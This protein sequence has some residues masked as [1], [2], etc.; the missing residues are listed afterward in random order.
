MASMAIFS[1]IFSCTPPAS[2]DEDSQSGLNENIS[3][4]ISVSSITTQTAKVTVTHD[5]EHTDTWYGFATTESDLDA[6]IEAK[7]DELLEP[8][9][10]TALKKTTSTTINLTGLEPGTAYEYVAFG[11]TEDGTV[12]GE[13]ASVSFNTEAAPEELAFKVNPAW[14]VKYLD[15]GTVNGQVYDNIISVESSDK[16]SYFITVINYSDW[17]VSSAAEIFASEL[18][19]IRSAAESNGY[20]FSDY[21]LTGSASQPWILPP[22]TE[23]IAI[24]V[25]VTAEGQLTGLYSLSDRIIIKEDATQSEG[26]KSWLGTW[27]LTSADK[28]ASFELTLSR[29]LNNYSYEMTGWEGFD[30]LPVEVLYDEEYEALEFYS[31]FISTQK[32]DTYGDGDIFFYGGAGQYYYN[33]DYL[34]AMAGQTDSG[35][36]MLGASIDDNTSFDSMFYYVVFDEENHGFISKSIMSLPATLVKK[37]EVTQSSSVSYRPERLFIP[38]MGLKYFYPSFKKSVSF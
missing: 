33:G 6:A 16:N 22:S 24:A 5:G 38:E 19:H 10:I 2:D 35:L 3:F 36:Q 29:K 13:P 27:T 31:Q 11:L 9:R 7:V 12:Y 26:Y 8:G 17:N 25:G 14:Y 1:C 28:K 4:T 21:I 34:I 15:Q 30:D 32:F 20:T 18:V 23:Y 37:S